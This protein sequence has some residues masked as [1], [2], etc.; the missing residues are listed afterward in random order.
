ME[1]SMECDLI[2][3]DGSLLY[4]D[5]GRFTR[6]LVNTQ[7]NKYGER[8]RALPEGLC[9]F[10]SQISSGRRSKAIVILAKPLE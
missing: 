8:K 1:K 9:W 2:E 4:I 10:V 6:L 7:T 3:A 5:L